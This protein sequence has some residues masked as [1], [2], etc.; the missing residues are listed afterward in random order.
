MLNS[1]AVAGIY[2]S[3]KKQNKPNQFKGY[4]KGV[5][6]L[7]VGNGMVSYHFCKALVARKLHEHFEIHVIGAE[8]SPE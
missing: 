2:T 7:V 1:K 5:K 3:L 4:K 8:K 6:L